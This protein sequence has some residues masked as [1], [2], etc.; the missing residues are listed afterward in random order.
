VTVRG[1]PRCGTPCTRRQAL[2]RLALAAGAGPAFLAGCD[3]HTDPLRFGAQVFPTYEL[4]FLARDLGYLAPDQVRLIETP[5]ASANVRALAAG[6][7][8]G[9]ALT[10][11]EVLAARERGLDLRVVAV[12]DVSVGANIVVAHPMVRKLSDLKG[13]VI[14]AEQTAVGAVMLDAALSDAG[15]TPSDVTIRHL[16]YADH[17]ASFRDGRVDA[18]VTY[19]PLGSR[20][21]LSGANEVYSSARIAGRIVDVMAVTA[22]TASRRASTIQALVDAHF[23]AR[24]A[25]THSPVRHAPRLAARLNL[26]VDLVPRAFFGLRLLDRSQNRAWLASGASEA[27]KMASGL[28][29]VMLR[30]GL[31][32]RTPDLAG[33]F[34]G[35]FV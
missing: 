28:G 33:L 27:L 2:R 9:A 7:M 5:S 3:S 20:L 16:E 26:Q 11:D 17:E 35:Q 23:L 29:A 6:G 31:L 4:L 1:G 21:V 8:E 15:L 18:L 30:A 34:D 22:E 13:R 14:G 24:D 19:D 12:L 32:R 25:W 10:L